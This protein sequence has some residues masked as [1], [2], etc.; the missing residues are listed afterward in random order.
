MSKQND[1]NKTIWQDKPIKKNTTTIHKQKMVLYTIQSKTFKHRFTRGRILMSCKHNF[2]L[3]D[4]YETI[5]ALC[6]KKQEELNE[7]K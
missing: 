6:N 3:Y 1:Q 5:C 7:G 2:L 4:E